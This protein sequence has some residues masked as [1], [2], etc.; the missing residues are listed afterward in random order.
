MR[1]AS[2]AGARSCSST[3][4]TASTRRSRTPSC[5]TSRIGL[6][7]FVGATTENPSFEVDRCAAVARARLC[8]ASRC[9]PT[10]CRSCSSARG[11]CM[12]RG[13]DRDSMPLPATMLI[14]LADGDARR[15][16]NTLEIT[17]AT[18]AAAARQRS[19]DVDFLRAT[20]RRH[21]APLR[22]GRREPSTTRSPRCTSRCA[23]PTRMRRCTGWC[24]CSMAAPIRAIWRGASIRMASEDIGLADPRA[25]RIALDAAEAYERLG[26]PE[27]E[28]ALAEAI[29][30]LAVAAKS[31]A[32][33]RAYGAGARFRAGATARAPVP[34]HLR[35]APTRLMKELGYGARLSLRTRRDGR[36]RGGRALPARRCARPA[37][38]YEP[39]DRGLETSAFARGCRLRRTDRGAAGAKPDD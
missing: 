9:R 5:R 18:R 32:V 2:A 23:A 28:L 21:A 30:Y 14:E 29:V 35:N 31:N 11:D 34:L 6:F 10:S 17:V 1:A 8:A 37:L 13:G 3:R 36:L 7:I 15:L 27:G 16:L 4:C 20:L 26:S 24:A 33:Y 39:T 19:I 25:L 38:L 22:Q 12:A